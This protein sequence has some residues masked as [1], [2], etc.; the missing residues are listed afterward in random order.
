M[1]WDRANIALGNELRLVEEKMDGPRAIAWRKQWEHH[2]RDTQAKDPEWEA[3]K[4][5][6]AHVEIC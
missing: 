4:F 3:P 5:S 6:F 1:V 2:V